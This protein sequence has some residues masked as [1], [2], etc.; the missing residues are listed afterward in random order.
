MRATSAPSNLQGQR[1]PVINCCVHK[2]KWV[3]WGSRGRKKTAVRPIFQQGAICERGKWFRGQRTNLLLRRS[4]TWGEARCN[5]G[6]G[7][8]EWLKKKKKKEKTVVAINFKCF[9]SIF[10]SHICLQFVFIREIKHT[11][12]LIC[13]TQTPPPHTALTCCTEEACFSK[14][15]MQIFHFTETFIM[16]QTFIEDQDFFLYFAFVLLCPTLKQT[17]CQEIQPE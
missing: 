8:Q 12:Y 14:E 4:W 5:G 2:C 3:H 6:G 11:V 13:Q 16:M 15:L 17:S 10:S 1:Q 7:S 9:I